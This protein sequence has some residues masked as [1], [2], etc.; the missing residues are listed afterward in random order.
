MYKTADV[1]HWKIDM[2]QSVV[3]LKAVTQFVGLS[4]TIK[5]SENCFHNHSVV[6]TVIYV[7]GKRVC[8]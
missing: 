2:V 1:V 7:V 8:T 6:E 3:V 5:V 4:R